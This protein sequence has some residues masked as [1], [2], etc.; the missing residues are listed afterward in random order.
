MRGTNERTVLCESHGQG[1]ETFVCIHLAN[2][3]SEVW[4]SAAPDHENRWPDAWCKKCHTAYS[5][6]NEWNAHSEETAQLKA[7]TLCHH[8]YEALKNSC[9][10]Y[11][12]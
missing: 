4:Y 6:E 3:E 7:R 1:H 8:C 12:V 11:V 10:K 2:G 9:E 5:A